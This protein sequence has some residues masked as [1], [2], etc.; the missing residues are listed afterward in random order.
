M[1]LGSLPIN[2]GSDF[3]YEPE[4]GTVKIVCSYDN[5]KYCVLHHSN[6][7]IKKVNGKNCHFNLCRFCCN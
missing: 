6:L 1:K 5:I 7:M 2:N 3:N 4:G